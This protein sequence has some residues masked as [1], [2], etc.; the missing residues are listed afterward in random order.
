M[1]PLPDNPAHKLLI[2]LNKTLKPASRVLIT[3]AMPISATIGNIPSAEP[4][5]I[6]H[7]HTG[8]DHA[9]GRSARVPRR[10]ML[11]RRQIPHSLGD[12]AVQC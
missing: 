9:R 1:R 5:Q 3:R 10:G 2:S 4:L 7:I 6:R 12:R 8:Y 11:P